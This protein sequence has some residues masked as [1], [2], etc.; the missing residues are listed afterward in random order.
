ML[1]TSPWSRFELTTAVL[2][3]DHG[4]DDPTITNTYTKY[5]L[6]ENIYLQ[7]EA[8]MKGYKFYMPTQTVAYQ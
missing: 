8:V 1:Y 6:K 2:Q 7:R 5:S 4:H 3:Y